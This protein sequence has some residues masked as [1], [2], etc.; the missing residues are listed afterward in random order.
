M[1][2][3]NLYDTKNINDVKEL[4]KQFGQLLETPASNMIKRIISEKDEIV[5]NSSELEL[6]KK[7]ILL[8]IYR[9]ASNSKSYE[10]P[11]IDEELIS[12]YNINKDESP[13]DFWKREMLTILNNSLS[14]LI[15]KTNLVGVKK[16]AIEI[17]QGFLMFFDTSEEFL[18]ND[19]GYVCERIPMPNISKENQERDIA[20]AEKYG[21]SVY[22]RPNMADSLRKE[23][24]EHKSYIDDMNI[25][26]IS[27]TM[28]VAVVHPIWLLKLTGNS[29]KEKDF[30]FESPILSKHLSFAKRENNNYSYK[31]QHLSHEE[32]VFTNFLIM[33]EALRFIGF[34][35]EKYAKFYMMNYAYCRDELHAPNFKK[36]FRLLINTIKE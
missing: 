28:F 10:N 9:N 4:E 36:D 6:I 30:K 13:L 29:A 18:I 22:G 16:H 25:C 3:S 8:Q 19:L 5:L 23:Y 20:Y 11:P 24:S 31:I 35:T 7:Y 26:P 27:S 15:T 1:C 34:K 14:D 2:V 32:T 21:A 12:Q 33:N 17:N